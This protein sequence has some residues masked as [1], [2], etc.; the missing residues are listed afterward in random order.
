MCYSFQNR[1]TT[2]IKD[3]LEFFNASTF[4]MLV[5]NEKEVV[6]NP[7]EPTE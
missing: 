2:Y 3:S 6:E 5:E 7:I 1:G 4:Y